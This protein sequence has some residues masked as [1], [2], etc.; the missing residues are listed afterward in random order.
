L[1]LLKLKGFP[2]MVSDVPTSAEQALKI[3]SQ[4]QKLLISL[5]IVEG[6]NGY[7]VLKLISE[8]VDSVVDNDEVLKS[9]RGLKDP[10]VLHVHSSFFSPDAALPIE[11]LDKDLALRIDEVKDNISIGLMTRSEDH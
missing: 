2:V 5:V 7:A 6:N 4:M 10:Q 8:G 11:P 9:S 3:L 1:E